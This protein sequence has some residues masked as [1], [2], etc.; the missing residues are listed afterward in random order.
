[1]KEDAEEAGRRQEDEGK[2][3]LMKCNLAIRLGGV[4][5][6]IHQLPLRPGLHFKRY[7]N[8]NRIAILLIVS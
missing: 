3:I 6:A 8:L 4:V 5:G 1:M 2:R 7:Y